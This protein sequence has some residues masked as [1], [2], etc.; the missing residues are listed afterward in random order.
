MNQGKG[1][2]SPLHVVARMSSGELVHLLM[3]F[4]ANAQTK[5][6]DGKRPVDLVPLESPVIEIFLQREGASPLP[7]SKP[8]PIENPLVL[9]VRQALTKF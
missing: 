8:Q 3:D 9:S 1:S 4:G 7:K 2:D 6:A 5:N